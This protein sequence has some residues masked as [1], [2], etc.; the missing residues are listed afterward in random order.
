M[1]IRP[2]DFLRS[3]I[4][5]ELLDLHVL[6]NVAASTAMN[7]YVLQSANLRNF[8]QRK[9]EEEGNLESQNLMIDIVFEEM[10]ALKHWA[11]FEDCIACLR[12]VAKFT[13][14]RVQMKY[15]NRGA[16]EYW[17]GLLQIWTLRSLFRSLDNC[18]HGTRRYLG[19][20]S[21]RCPDRWGCARC[22]DVVECLPSRC[23]MLFVASRCS[24][25][26]QCHCGWWKLLSWFAAWSAMIST[27]TANECLRIT[28]SSLSCQCGPKELPKPRH[29]AMLKK[30]C[31]CWRW[32]VCVSMERLQLTFARYTV[33]K[34]C[35]NAWTSRVS[36]HNTVTIIW[37]RC[38]I[39]TR[40][41]VC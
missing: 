9:V 11:Q 19:R 33:V 20:T 30:A 25:G 34:L 32:T 29:S 27:Q 35:C 18:L 12:C 37:S 2:C 10:A 5:F 3:A 24:L 28:L 15:P 16:Q 41:F 39:C 17:Y 40:A 31:S 21:L 1:A 14:L 38:A 4:D 13:V 23:S 7:A 8:L 36:Y 26:P 22:G 6:I